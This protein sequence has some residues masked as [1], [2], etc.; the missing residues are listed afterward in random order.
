MSQNGW[1][2]HKAT[3]QA[4]RFGL[5][6]EERDLGNKGQGQQKGSEAHEAKIVL[7]TAH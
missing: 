3:M 5:S 6:G 2:S 1:H 4:Q 7:L